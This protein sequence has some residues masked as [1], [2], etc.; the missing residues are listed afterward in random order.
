MR[1]LEVEHE[2]F[3]HEIDP[4]HFPSSYKYSAV[5]TTEEC[6]DK[7]TIEEKLSLT[8]GMDSATSLEN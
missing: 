7:K 6:D 1:W 2:I 3:N 8:N 4:F 5:N